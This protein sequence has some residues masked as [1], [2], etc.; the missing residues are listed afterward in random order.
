MHKILVITFLLKYLKLFISLSQA[1]V[2]SLQ[3]EEE[4]K[5]MLLLWFKTYSI[6]DA[7]P[8][9]GAE[10]DHK[11]KKNMQGGPLGSMSI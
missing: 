1:G 8:P 4:K 10:R 6:T 2:L 3:K 7:I 9:K 11:K 5:K